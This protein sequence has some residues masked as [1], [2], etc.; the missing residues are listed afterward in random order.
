M[1]S[2]LHW[3]WFHTVLLENFTDDA[4]DE[5]FYHF[6]LF[7]ETLRHIELCNSVIS[8]VKSTKTFLTVYRSQS[9]TLKQSPLYSVHF[10]LLYI[11][12]CTV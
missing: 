6:P 1:Q 11:V 9:D 5:M 10:I 12:H 7:D 8:Q 3:N 2:F 4:I